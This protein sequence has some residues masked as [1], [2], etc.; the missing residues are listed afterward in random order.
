VIFSSFNNPVILLPVQTL[1]NT[2]GVAVIGVVIEQQEVFIID[3]EAAMQ[4]NYKILLTL[5]GLEIG[6]AETHVVELAKGLKE[7]GFTVIV[8]SNGGVYVKELVNNGIKHYKVPLH[9]KIPHNVIKSYSLLKKIITREKIDLV[10]AHARIPAFICNILQKQLGF[11]YVTTAHWVFTTKWGLKYLTNWGQKTIAVSEDI[12]DYLIVNYGLP[13]S[14]IYVTINGINPKTFSPDIDYSDVFEEF[15]LSRDNIHI[16]HVSRLSK[17]KSDVAFQLVNIAEEL[18]SRIPNLDI[19]IVGDGNAFPRLRICADKV[20]GKLGRRVV[21]LTGGRTDINKF[22]AFSDLFIGISRA[23]LEAMSASKPVILTGNEGYI[24]IFDDD[25]L[26]IAM[27][28]NFTGRG[29][30]MPDKD[31]LKQDIFKVLLEM[32]DTQKKALG[33]YGKSIIDKYYSIDRMVED[34]I[35]V[36][37]DKLKNN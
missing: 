24:G 20:N 27:N 17:D 25:K 35:K 33:A 22:I 29:M 16:V 10:H 26:K 13:E 14:R 21:V 18:V 19:V 1:N 28:T 9:N 11:P 32:D 15:N 6:G 12:K 7:R 3:L 36:Y 23:A 5:M 31:M 37:M 8:A 4:Y 34:N 2:T 30:G